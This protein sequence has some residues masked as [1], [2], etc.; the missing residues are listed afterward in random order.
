VLAK[1]C[2][3]CHG[4]RKTEGDLRLDLARPGLRWRLPQGKPEGLVYLCLLSNPQHGL[5]W[6]LKLAGGKIAAGSE[7]WMNAIDVPTKIQLPPPGPG[8]LPFTAWFSD[9]EIPEI[10]G[11][12]TTKDP[13]LLGVGDYIPQED[14]KTGD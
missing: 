8:K 9:E 11:G 13:K 6:D 12:Q 3:S 14:R 7:I 1:R 10:Q 2:L 4:A 5:V